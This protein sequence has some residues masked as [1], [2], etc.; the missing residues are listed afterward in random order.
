MLF[1]VS[2]FYDKRE[3]IFRTLPMNPED[4]YIDIRRDHDNFINYILTVRI[5]ALISCI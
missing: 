3:I 5:G 1:E 4:P 2:Q